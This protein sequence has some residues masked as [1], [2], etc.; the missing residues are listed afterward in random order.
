MQKHFQNDLNRGTCMSKINN[1]NNN[2]YAL[3]Y[4][5]KYIL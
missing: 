1:Y 2:N 3:I 5:V 4:I